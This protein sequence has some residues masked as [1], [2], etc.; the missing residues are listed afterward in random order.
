[1]LCPLWIVNGAMVHEGD[2]E[3]ISGCGNEA[4]KSFAAEFASDRGYH[5]PAQLRDLLVFQKLSQELIPRRLAKMISHLR[6][7]S[8]FPLGDYSYVRAKGTLFVIFRPDNVF[9][10]AQPNNLV[11]LAV[12]IVLLDGIRHRTFEI[13]KLLQIF[14]QTSLRQLCRGLAL[15]DDLRLRGSHSA[16][17]ASLRMTAENKQRRNTG[18]LRC[19]QNDK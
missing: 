8:K 17:L 11:L 19:A 12:A 14:L 13:R 7:V 18:V 15:C 1:M 5:F 4:V 10:N 2:L 6:V 3:E 9:S 16:R